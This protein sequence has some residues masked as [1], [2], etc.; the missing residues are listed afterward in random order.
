[1]RFDRRWFGMAFGPVDLV[2]ST[3]L[4]DDKAAPTVGETI[5]LEEKIFGPYTVN[6][7]NPDT[8]SP[9]QLSGSEQ[10]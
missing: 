2:M 10:V 5:I 4:G 9:Y 1:M 7:T 8:G 3:A 6:S